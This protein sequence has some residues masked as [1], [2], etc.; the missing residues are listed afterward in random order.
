MLAAASQ[1]VLA[2]QIAG[3]RTAQVGSD[4]YRVITYFRENNAEGQRIR[5]RL[6]EV[7]RLAKPEAHTAPHGFDEVRRVIRK[8]IDEARRRAEPI[9]KLKEAATEDYAWYARELVQVANN[10]DDLSRLWPPAHI[11]EEPLTES[12][13]RAK[14]SI[15]VLDDMIFTCAC[16]TIPD[17]LNN[18]LNN[19]RIGKSLDFV[20]TFKDQLPDEASTRALLAKLAP[21]SGIVSGLIDL[22]NAKVIK[23]DQRW[24]RQV[25]SVAVVLMVAGIGFGLVAI[26]VHLGTW[27]QFN[28][29]SW[30][31]SQN[32]WAALNGAYLLV[33][34]GV[35]G[36]W[37]LDRVQQSRAGA[38]VTPLSEWLMWIH[39]NEVPIT[40]RIA[41]VWL[42]VLLGIGFRTFDL[43]KG[44][45]PLTYFTA[46]YFMDSTFDALVGRFNTFMSSND[47]SKKKAQKTTG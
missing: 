24:W 22:D 6:V 40:I 34:L 18:Y 35:L 4:F 17:E 3:G 16:Q 15:Q 42:I 14:Q 2:A 12:V 39:I 25:M 32:Q 20:A 10:W 13:A 1:P 21:Q 43:A 27:L 31:V 19:Y 9:E 44:V 26:A 29:G 46:G 47:P 23:A 36:H 41:T 11:E 37:V 33:L 8:E 5:K 28:P 30:P 45:Q 7:I 38:D